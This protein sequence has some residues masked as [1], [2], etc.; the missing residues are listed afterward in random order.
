VLLFS[1]PEGEDRVLEFEAFDIAPRKVRKSGAG[2]P[3]L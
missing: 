2:P 3:E 1:T